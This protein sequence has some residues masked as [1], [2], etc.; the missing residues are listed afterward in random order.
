MPFDFDAQLSTADINE[1]RVSLKQMRSDIQE[2]SITGSEE[3]QE[4]AQFLLAIISNLDEEIAGIKNLESLEL[5][6]K[7]RVIAFMNLFYEC[8]NAVLGD[9]EDDDDYDDDEDDDDFD[10][11]DDDD[12]FE[13]EDF[14]EEDFEEK[15]I[16]KEKCV[17]DSCCKS[18]KQI[19]FPK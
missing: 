18:N 3:F 17:K 2:G 11:D 14:D 7:V 5:N 4:Q 10:E 16:E 13:D 12:D 1:L 9:D 6:K 19:Q 8:L 15:A